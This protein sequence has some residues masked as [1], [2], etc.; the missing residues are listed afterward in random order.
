MLGVDN[1]AFLKHAMSATEL[2]N[3]KL[4]STAGAQLLVREAK[5]KATAAA[6]G[7]KPVYQ[8]TAPGPDGYTVPTIPERIRDG[9][10]PIAT[11]L[12]APDAAL[13]LDALVDLESAWLGGNSL[14]HTFFI[15]LYMQRSTLDTLERLVGDVPG[16]SNATP[17]PA[18][19]D[20]REAAPPLKEL[21]LEGPLAAGTP[22]HTVSLTV[23]AYCTAML[24]TVSAL[25]ACYEAAMAWAVR[26]WGFSVR[27]A[28]VRQSCLIIGCVS[29]WLVCRR[30]ITM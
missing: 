5:A 9:S 18:L 11:S 23:L 7:D 6:G 14:A 25:Q 4:D 21:G 22:G 16:V 20:E 27:V 19:H 10:L 15:C 24:R 2:G 26:A 28:G 29:V 17:A 3:V 13:V 1:S 8:G 30:R 12:T